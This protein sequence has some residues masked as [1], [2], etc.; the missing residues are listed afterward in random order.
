M[1]NTR[2]L[3]VARGTAGTNAWSLRRTNCLAA[4]HNGD[5]ETGSPLC[6]AARQFVRLKLQAF[7][8]AVPRATARRRVLLIT[9]RPSGQDDVAYRSI[10]MKVFRELTQMAEYDR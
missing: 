1:S 7:V 3:A 2:R 10:A 9:S 4:K 6:L 5:P 8:P